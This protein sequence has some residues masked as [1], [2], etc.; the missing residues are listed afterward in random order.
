[1]QHLIEHVRYTS[2][3]I[4][5]SAEYSKAVYEA[6]RNGSQVSVLFCWVAKGDVKVKPD[7][8]AW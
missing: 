1:M 7:L 4:G 3:S 5:S 2:I 8:T 6:V